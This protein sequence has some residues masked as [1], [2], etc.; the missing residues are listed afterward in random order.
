METFFLVVE[1]RS[2]RTLF[3]Q[4]LFVTPG[5]TEIGQDNSKKQGVPAG[6][7]MPQTGR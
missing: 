2:M 1:K 7:W 6:A 4:D 3:Y 5:T